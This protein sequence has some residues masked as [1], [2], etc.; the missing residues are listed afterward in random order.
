MSVLI[1]QFN[2]KRQQWTGLLYRREALLHMGVPYLSYDRE[3][4][5]TDQSIGQ[6]V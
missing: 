3:T 1:M 4:S 6:A 5:I 2:Q